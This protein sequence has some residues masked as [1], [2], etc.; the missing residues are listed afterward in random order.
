MQQER[1]QE[2]E[3]SRRTKKESTPKGKQQTVER[4]E[5]KS[6][7]KSRA[8]P[9]DSPARS[10]TGSVTDAAPPVVASVELR[11]AEE[12][13]TVSDDTHRERRLNLSTSM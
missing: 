4:D 2:E 8:G 7:P 11:P 9:A 13:V 6:D 1:L 12:R 3:A 5:T 10:P